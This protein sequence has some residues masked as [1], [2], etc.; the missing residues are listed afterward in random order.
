MDTPQ[1]HHTVAH[2][3][4]VD[5]SPTAQRASVRPRVQIIDLT[6]DPPARSGQGMPTPPTHR[7]AT[8]TNSTPPTAKQLTYL[9]TLANRTGTTFTTPTS[10]P[11]ASAEIRRLKTIASTGFTFAELDTEQAARQARSEEHTSELQSLR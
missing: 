8:M 2:G 9:R 7:S 4:Q 1:A 5:E 3:R 10:R 6:A 11:Q